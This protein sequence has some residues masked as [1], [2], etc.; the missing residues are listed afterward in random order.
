MDIINRITTT[1]TSSYKKKDF[2]EVI[3]KELYNKYL[4]YSFD[5]YT[6]SMNWKEF[7]CLICKWIFEN[8]EHK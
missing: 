4:Y 2:F 8:G 3:I 1:Y 7:I 6:I 5:D